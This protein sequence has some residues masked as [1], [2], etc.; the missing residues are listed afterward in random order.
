MSALSRTSGSAVPYGFYPSRSEW[1]SLVYSFDNCVVAKEFFD[2]YRFLG[3]R[4]LLEHGLGIRDWLV[5]VM[6]RSMIT[7]INYL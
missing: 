2:A 4:G 5:D 6:Q 7:W 1:S 3:D